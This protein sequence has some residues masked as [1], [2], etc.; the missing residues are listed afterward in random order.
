MTQPLAAHMSDESR[1]R[2]QPYLDAQAESIVVPIRILLS[3]I[4]AGASAAELNDNLTQII[5]IVQS[6]VSVCKGHL[7]P[8]SAK[9][10][11]DILAQLSDNCNKLSELQAQEEMTKQTRQVMAAS[12]F[13]VAKAIKELRG[14]K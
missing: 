12:S 10:G 14:L 1:D 4:R 3:S 9:V 11:E 13:A 5:A 6:V 2:D 8:G 7:P